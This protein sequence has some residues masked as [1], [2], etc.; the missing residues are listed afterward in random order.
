MD[1]QIRKRRTFD[2]IKQI[3]LRESMRQPLMVIF[4][5]LHWIDTETQAFLNLL[6]DSIATAKVLLLVNY[7]PEYRH[8]WGSRTY[9]TQLR[10]DPL[11]GKSA[12]DML[13]AMLGDGIELAPLKHLIIDKTEGNPFFMEETV[14]ALFDDGAL[15]RNGTVKL[16]RS[17]S[18]LKIPPT[19]QAILA[20]RMDRL[21]PDEK[22]LL[23]TL[24]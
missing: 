14:Q 2:A 12:E 10:L 22:E 23:Q 17:L 20:S 15:V 19:V 3:L 1:A 8:E 18:Q 11:S 4:E 16:T 5:D 13:S 7:R 6:A 21:L 9:Y 24:R